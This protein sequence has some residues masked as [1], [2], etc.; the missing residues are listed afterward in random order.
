MST[1]TEDLSISNLFPATL[2]PDAWMTDEQLDR[3]LS[4]VFDGGRMRC[5]R[6][7]LGKLR[8]YPPCPMTTWLMMQRVHTELEGWI[9]RSERP[10]RAFFRKRFFFEQ[11]KLMLCPDVAYFIPPSRSSSL[12]MSHSSKLPNRPGCVIEFCSHPK[13]LRALKDKMLQW[14][15]SGITLAWLLVPQEECVF[16]YRSGEEPEIIDGEWVGEGWPLS[17]FYLFL[18]PIWSLDVYRRKY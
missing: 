14:M 16:V 13:E 6:D 10:G 1:T 8:I 11:S 7:L 17:D 12:D 15:A 2:I 18:E 4:N 5:E 3:I 9:K